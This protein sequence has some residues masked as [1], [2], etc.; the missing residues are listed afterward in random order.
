MRKPTV[1]LGMLLYLGYLAIFFAAWTINGV[2]YNRIG[3]NPETTRLWYALP[4]LSGCA[5]LVI[6]L[7]VLGWWRVALFERPQAGPRW[8]WILHARARGT[9]SGETC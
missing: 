4:T 3:E 1:T 6:A 9:T 8:I 7:S 5:F 2:D